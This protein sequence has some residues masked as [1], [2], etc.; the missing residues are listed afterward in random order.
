MYYLIENKKDEC[1]ILRSCI[2]AQQT[3]PIL[4]NELNIRDVTLVEDVDMEDKDGLYCIPLGPNKYI[5]YNICISPDGIFFR[6]NT[7]V[8]KLYCLEWVHYIANELPLE[9]VI[10]QFKKSCQI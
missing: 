8:D 7:H 9:R 6:G 1:K 5:V 2:D 3:Q 4:I 10:K